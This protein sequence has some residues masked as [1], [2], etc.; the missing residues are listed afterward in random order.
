MD[1]GILPESTSQILRFGYWQATDQQAGLV[2]P[3][4]IRIFAAAGCGRKPL[5]Q[6]DQLFVTDKVFIV[7]KK[8]A[9]RVGS[10]QKRSFDDAIGSL[11]SRQFRAVLANSQ[12]ESWFGQHPIAG[13][14]VGVCKRLWRLAHNIQ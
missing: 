8:P 1:K 13:Q 6:S 9:A 2:R 11:P 7:G 3:S 10:G 14:T 4:M 5:D 12:H